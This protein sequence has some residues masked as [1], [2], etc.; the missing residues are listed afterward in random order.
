MPNSEFVLSWKRLTG[1]RAGIECIG[2]PLAPELVVPP[3]SPE[4]RLELLRGADV[5]SARSAHQRRLIRFADWADE[6][7]APL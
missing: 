4:R 2:K 6:T 3:L 1:F 7:S 5:S